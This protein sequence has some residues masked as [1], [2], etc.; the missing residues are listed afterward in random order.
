MNALRAGWLSLA[1]AAL[2][3]ALWAVD[4]TQQSVTVDDG[5]VIAG[6]VDLNVLRAAHDGE[7]VLIDLR[8]EAEGT[9]EEAAAAE[10]LG[11]RYENIPVSSADIDPDQVSALSSAMASAGD[12]ALIVVHCASGNRA[13]M[14]WSAVQVRDGRPLEAVRSSVEGILTSPRLIE[15]LSAYADSVAAPALP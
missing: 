13:A 9:P 1:V 8:T 7:V 12:D 14:L 2:P 4:Y 3:V 6:A 5:V 11:M 10:A 15:G